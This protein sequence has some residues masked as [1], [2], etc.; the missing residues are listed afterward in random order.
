MYDFLL[1]VHV[2]AAVLWVGGGATSH[3]LLRRAQR[4]NDPEYRLA[5]VREVSTIG[6]RLYAP[7][8]L[9]LVIAGSLLVNEAGYEFSQLWITLGYTAWLVSFALGIGFYSRQQKRIDELAEREGADG[10]GTSADIRRILTVN[11]VE[12]LI[13]VLAVIDMTAKPGI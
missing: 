8:S 4:T 3:V 12:L 7:L 13:L 2:L 11:S 10:P 9:V 5:L 6:N 1:A